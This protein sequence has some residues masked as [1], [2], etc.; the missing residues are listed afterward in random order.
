MMEAGT[1]T[2]CRRIDNL[3]FP[4]WVIFGSGGK[5]AMWSIRAFVGTMTGREKG[6]SRLLEL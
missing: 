4:H 1:G 3:L 2:H 5:A 6:C